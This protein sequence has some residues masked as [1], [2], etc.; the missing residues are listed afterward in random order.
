MTPGTSGLPERCGAELGI[1]MSKGKTDNTPQILC[2]ECFM[3]G[4]ELPSG[5]K[6][7]PC[8][9]LALSGWNR[10]PD[11]GERSISA[12]GWLCVPVDTPPSGGVDWLSP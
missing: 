1:H 8:K 6:C 4:S 10:M 3:A 11:G 9:A 12:F 5:G 2:V 7:R